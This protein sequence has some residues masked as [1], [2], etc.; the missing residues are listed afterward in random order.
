MPSLRVIIVNFNAGEALLDCLEALLGQTGNMAVAVVDNASEDGSM[1]SVRVRFG[2]DPRLELHGN[3]TNLGFARAV[4]QLARPA[5]EDYL[6]V[7]NPDCVLQ[8]AA[9]PALVESL[10]RQPSAAVSGPWVTDQQG[11]VQSGTWRRLPDPRR[12]LMT[13]SGLHHFSGRSAAL[14]GINDPRSAPPAEVT[15]VE[16][17]SGACMLLR[18]SA[19]E[20]VGFFDE[21]YAMHCE[22]LDLMKRL[23]LQGWTCLLVPQARAVHWGGVSSGS[24]PWWVHR[25]KHVGMQ[26]Y[27][28]KFLAAEHAL[29]MRWLIYAGIWCHYLVTLP[30][31]WFRQRSKFT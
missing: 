8:P 29:P 10:D 28:R 14:S 24:R 7:L 19:V 27:F 25:Q 26:R 1:E 5:T 18:R 23:R 16:A 12:A 6:L 30:G 4:N 22:D 21:S 3:P 11:S 15:E 17:V 20:A 9:L 2:K 13:V 31:V